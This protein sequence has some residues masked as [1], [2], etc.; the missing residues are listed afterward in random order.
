MRI[1]AWIACLL[2]IPACVVGS[3]DY[4]DW[5]RIRYIGSQDAPIPTIYITTA[6]M[7]FD[8]STEMLIDVV[9][10]SAEYETVFSNLRQFKAERRSLLVT[11]DFGTLAVSHSAYGVEH[12][13]F[14][15]SRPDSCDLLEAIVGSQHSE[16]LNLLREVTIYTGRR[17]G[18]PGEAFEQ[19]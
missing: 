6:H 9:L 14:T 15:I 13:L 16:S 12:L 4:A 3:E 2:C 19:P 7:D 11:D 8:D 5:I 10:S 1:C 18:C 17:I